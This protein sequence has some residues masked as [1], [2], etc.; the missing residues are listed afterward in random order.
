MGT[1]W[2]IYDM[3]DVSTVKSLVKENSVTAPQANLAIFE[4]GELCL[5]IKSM[6]KHIALT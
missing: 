2:L 3:Q 5:N 1:Y 4:L 6:A